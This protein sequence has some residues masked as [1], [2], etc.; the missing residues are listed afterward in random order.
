MYKKDDCGS[1]IYIA[2]L[3]QSLTLLLRA[4][5][6]LGWNWGEVLALAIKVQLRIAPFNPFL[7][8]Y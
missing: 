1:Q 3:R 6:S 4:A 5:R 7:Y 8:I 2:W